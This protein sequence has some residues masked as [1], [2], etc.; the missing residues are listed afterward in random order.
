MNAKN[1][2]CSFMYNIDY[3][4]CYVNR[5]YIHRCYQKMSI[6]FCTHREVKLPVVF[7][8]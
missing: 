8:G 7:V 2:K 3:K 4:C 1:K 5:M 6:T